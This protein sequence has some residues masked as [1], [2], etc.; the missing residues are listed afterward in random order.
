M[1]LSCFPNAEVV[2]MWEKKQSPLERIQGTRCPQDRIRLL[3]WRWM[4]YSLEWGRIQGYLFSIKMFGLEG[5]RKLSEQCR[6]VDWW[7]LWLGSDPGWS[8]CEA[9]EITLAAKFP[10][11]WVPAKSWE[12]VDYCFF[13]YLE[14]FLLDA[15]HCAFYLFGWWIF[16]F[17]SKYSWAL[18]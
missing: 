16:L 8:K 10:K 13:E 11:E 7:G 12:M 18:F 2:H 14:I 6:R 17:S 1:I 15:R 3:T 5:R 9:W 4:E